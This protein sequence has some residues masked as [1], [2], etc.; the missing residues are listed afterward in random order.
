MVHDSAFYPNTKQISKLFA[1]KLIGNNCNRITMKSYL[2]FT[3]C[4]RLGDV[5]AQLNLHVPNFRN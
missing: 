4:L 3:S 1:N 5:I 2:M